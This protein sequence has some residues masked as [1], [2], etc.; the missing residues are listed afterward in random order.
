METAIFPDEA[1]KLIQEALPVKERGPTGIICNICH[2]KTNSS[3]NIKGVL[4]R[5]GSVLI[6]H[7][8]LELTVPQGYSRLLYFYNVCKL[9]ITPAIWYRPFQ[10]QLNYNDTLLIAIILLSGIFLIS[11]CAMYIPDPLLVLGNFFAKLC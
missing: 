8:L 11:T 9:K 3:D 1:T 6:F 2:N 7:V 10:L 5:C 4:Y